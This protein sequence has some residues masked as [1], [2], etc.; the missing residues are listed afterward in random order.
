MMS[1]FGRRARLAALFGFMILSMESWRTIPFLKPWGADLHNLQGFQVCTNGSS[2]Y[3]FDP[4]KCDVWSRPMIYPPLMYRSFAWLR[5]MSLERAMYIWCPILVLAFL[6]ALYAWLRLVPRRADVRDDERSTLIVFGVLLLLQFPFVFS[7]ER[8]STDAPAVVLW[9]LAAYWFERRKL[10]ASGAA[11]GLATAYK[12]YPVFACLVVGAGLLVAALRK[13]G[14]VWLDAVRFGG[15][16][17]AAF[18]AANAIQ[19]DAVHYFT[20]I[21]PRFANL[22]TN[23]EVVSHSIPTFVGADFPRFALLLGLLLVAVWVFA[24][25]ASLRSRAPVVFAG[26]LAMSTFSSGTSWDYNLTTTYPLLLLTF[27]AALRTGR[28][29]LIALGIFSI[30]ANRAWFRHADADFLTPWSHLALELA[31]VVL[32]A[33]AAADPEAEASAPPETVKS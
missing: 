8:G 21:L 17:A 18:V 28:F 12:L 3:D 32:A 7:L 4:H 16:A 10:A 14:F 5:H 30:C 26:A 27:A 15:G 23:A 25:Q 11:G 1:L 6:A 22:V 31:F 33:L 13:R 9:T 19:P 2:P 20:V 29:A 24:A